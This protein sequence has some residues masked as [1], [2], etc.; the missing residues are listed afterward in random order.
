MAKIEINRTELVWPGK[1]DD[2]GDRVAPPRVNLPFQVI[3]TINESRATREA[4]KKPA[5]TALFDFW[6]GDEGQTFEEGWKNKL[7]WGDN[8][9][10]MSSLLEQYAG[11]ID[12]IYIDPPFATGADF[13]VRAPLG[14]GDDELEKAQSIIEEKVYR[15]SWGDGLNSY[16]SM[17]APR[18]ELMKALLSPTGSLYVH[19]DWR[20]NSHLRLLLDADFGAD[21]FRNEIE[22]CYSGGGVPREDYPRKHDTILRYVKGGGFVFNVEYKPYK[23]NTQQVGKHSTYVDESRRDIDLTRGTPVTDWWTDIQTV[24]GWNPEKVGFPTQKPEALLTRIITASSRP[25]DLV[26]D[27]FIGSGTTAAVA[28]K[29]GRRWIAADLGRFSVHTT[30]KRLMGIENCRPF[31]VMNLG[32]YERQY[33]Q[34][35][36]FQGRDPQ[37][38]VFEYLAFLLK[39]YGATPVAGMQH[40]HGKKGGALVHIGAVDAPVTIDEVSKSLDECV[41]TGQKELHILGWEWEMGLNDTVDQLASERSVRMKLLAIPREVMEARAVD[42]GDIRFFELAHLDCTIDVRPKRQAAVILSGFAMSEGD[43][44]DPEVLARIEKWS[45]FVDYWAIDWDFKNDT[46]VNGWVGY[47]TRKERRLSLKGDPHTYEAPGTYRIAVKV[48]DIFGNDTTKVFPVEV[49]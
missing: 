43:G 25:S 26:A 1:Y 44:I 20:V 3:E 28:E 45:D 42:R 36:S 41:A 49:R 15:D 21:A 5:Q 37:Q 34:V 12:L 22:W 24:T 13:S 17:M 48:V 9:L 31:D 33:W 19:C 6:G 39:L 4:R 27:F 38:V 7:I 47:R 10:V 23:E 32:K 30:R 40:I 18:L 14:E 8:A 16:L 2:H 29:L 11:K 35:A 46:F